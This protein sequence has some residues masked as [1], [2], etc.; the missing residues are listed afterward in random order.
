MTTGSA[1]FRGYEEVKETHKNE[2][3][4][5]RETGREKDTTERKR[6]C[7]TVKEEETEPPMRNKETNVDPVVKL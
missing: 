4:R 5:K 3:Q 2:N 6:R 7:T 1:L